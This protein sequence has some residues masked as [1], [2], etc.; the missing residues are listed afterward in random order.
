MSFALIDKNLFSLI[1]KHNFAISKFHLCVLT[2]AL[3]LSLRMRL[4]IAPLILF[5]ELECKEKLFSIWW[6]NHIWSH[7]TS[8]VKNFSLFFTS[9]EERS[10][11]YDLEIVIINIYS[12]LLVEVLEKYSQ[13]FLSICTFHIINFKAFRFEYAKSWVRELLINFSWTDHKYFSL[14]CDLPHSVTP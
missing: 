2:C 11:I 5:D 9:A 13:D 14:H 10:K 3:S 4:F 6:C 1:G 8:H 7:R 12:S